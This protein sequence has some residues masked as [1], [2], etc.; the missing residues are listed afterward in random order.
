MEIGSGTI[1]LTATDEDNNRESQSIYIDVNDWNLKIPVGTEAAPVTPVKLTGIA[2]E[3][4]TLRAVFDQTL[5]PDLVPSD[6]SA[7]LVVYTWHRFDKGGSASDSNMVKSGISDS[8]TLTQADVGKH[9]YVEVEYVEVETV[10]NQPTDLGSF[11]SGGSAT[12]AAAVMNTQ[13]PASMSFDLLTSVT[14]GD[15]DSTVAELKP[16]VKI[17]DPDGVPTPADPERPAHL[18]LG[19]FRERSGWLDGGYRDRCSK[20]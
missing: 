19:V 8:Y 18:H 6:I 3:G 5:D 2:R 13:D 10:L 1:T 14:T 9:I 16:T 12:T 20:G 15:G 7:Q 11:Q 4:L 17:S